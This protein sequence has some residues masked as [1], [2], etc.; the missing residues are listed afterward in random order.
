MIS[1]NSGFNVLARTSLSSWSLR[2]VKLLKRTLSLPLGAAADGFVCKQRL[3]ATSIRSTKVPEGV[4]WRRRHITLM[5]SEN[6]YLNN[7]ASGRFGKVRVFI[8]L[9]R[10]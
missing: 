6:A 8:L 10:L 1:L 9:P 2:D 7:A 4:N 3:V 5:Q